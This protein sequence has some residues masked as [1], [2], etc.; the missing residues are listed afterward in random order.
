M[1]VEAKEVF[2]YLGIKAEDI[3]DLD[4]FKATFEKDFIK[5]SNI[6]EDS[7][8]VKKLLGKTFGTLENEIKKISKSF[9]L[10]IDFEE[11]KDKKVTEK[12]KYAF[13]KY[14]DKKSEYIKDLETKAGQGNDEKIKELEKKYEKALQKSKDFESLLTNTKSEY[15]NAQNKWTSEI[16]NVK[17]NVLTKDAFGKVKLKSDISEFE[18]KGYYSTISEKYNF[19]LDETENIIVKNSKGERIPSSKTTGTFK[20]IDEILEEEAI[21]G[22]LFK[23]NQDGGKV[24]QQI[25]F[26]QPVTQS[27]TQT[28]LRKI[29]PRLG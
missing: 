12:L 24:K 10:D 5:Q 23:V 15:E 18:K 4:T 20:T 13:E 27:E 1:A 17:L 8:P 25:N 29:A 9:D 2:E 16:K 21:A 26:G 3:K 28:P 22:N 6:N 19:D 7:E 11:V 14:N